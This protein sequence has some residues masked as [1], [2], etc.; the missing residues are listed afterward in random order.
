M[1][2]MPGVGR[3]DCQWEVWK[4]SS[5]VRFWSIRMA[6]RNQASGSVSELVKI[7]I[8]RPSTLEVQRGFQH[9]HGRGFGIDR[10]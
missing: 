9:V 10:G 7:I 4:A 3:L 2:L 8:N 1:W 5:A 6:R